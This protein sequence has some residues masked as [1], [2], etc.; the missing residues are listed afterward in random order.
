MT[1]MALYQ[2]SEAATYQPLDSDF[3]YV[4]KRI[5]EP[6]KGRSGYWV[7]H[8]KV[9]ATDHSLAIAEVVLKSDMEIIYQGVNKIIPKGDCSYYGAVMKAKDGKTLGYKITQKHEAVE[10]ILAYKQGKPSVSLSEISRYRFI[11]N[12]Y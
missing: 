1:V 8:L 10:Q 3:K 11:L 6:L 2:P 4:E 7:Y 9:C 12:V 5:A